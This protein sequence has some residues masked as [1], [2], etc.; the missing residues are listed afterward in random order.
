MSLEPPVTAPAFRSRLRP[1]TILE[2]GVAR[3]A[4]AELT[5]D[6]HASTAGRLL[7]VVMRLETIRT[8]ALQMALQPCRPH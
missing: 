6:R 2:L 5:G 4:T 3:G 7:S 1:L 8:T